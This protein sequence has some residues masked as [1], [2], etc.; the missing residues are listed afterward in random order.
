MAISHNENPSIK[1]HAVCVLDGDSRKD[2]SAHE[3]IFK[4]PGEMPE[5]HVFDCVLENWDQVGG[6]LTVSLLQDFL[7]IDKVK[8]ILTEVRMSNRD[9]HVLFGQIGERLGFIP[10]KTVQM[11][12]ANTWS[13]LFKAEVEDIVTS[14]RK[15]VEA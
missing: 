10:E 5:A 2:A 6:R 4:L 14:I 11:A 15:H 13:Q 12:F 1:T 8:S 9:Q 3:F 7:N